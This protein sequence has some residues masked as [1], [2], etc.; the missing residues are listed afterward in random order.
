[1]LSHRSLSYLS[2]S[3]R[4]HRNRNS[5]QY[6]R[7]QAMVQL[8]PIRYC[9][10]LLTPSNSCELCNHTRPSRNW[11]FGRCAGC[12]ELAECLPSRTWLSMVSLVARN[13]R[14]SVPV[15]STPAELHQ[16][17]YPSAAAP[18]CR[19]TCGPQRHLRARPSI[20]TPAPRASGLKSVLS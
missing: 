8:I 4:G 3:L 2:P 18:Q 9:V 17:T 7:D 11:L 6:L 13:S 5:C 14:L 19:H 16:S 12:K 10:W 15:P 1:M 20:K